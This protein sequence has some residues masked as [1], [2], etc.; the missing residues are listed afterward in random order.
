MPGQRHG[1]VQGKLHPQRGAGIEQ[2]ASLRHHLRQ[3]RLLR[4]PERNVVES[5]DPVGGRIPL[6][7]APAKV[8]EPAE[9]PGLPDTPSAGPQT[10]A[11]Q[12]PGS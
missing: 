2:P 7:A 12:R 10:P 9:G 11:S 1:P 5:K 6:P 3:G 4:H 8:P